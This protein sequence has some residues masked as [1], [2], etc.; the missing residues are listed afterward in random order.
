MLNHARKMPCDKTNKI[1]FFIVS[2]ME[3][4]RGSNFAMTFK[5]YYSNKNSCK[6]ISGKANDEMKECI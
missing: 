2:L 3:N 5:S 6:S 1:F 4:F